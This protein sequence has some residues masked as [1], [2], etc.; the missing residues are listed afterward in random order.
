MCFS[1][2]TKNNFMFL[3][4]IIQFVDSKT[5]L[6][7]YKFISWKAKHEEFLLRYYFIPVAFWKL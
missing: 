4:D 1:D 3:L 6:F 5:A 2:K 7:I